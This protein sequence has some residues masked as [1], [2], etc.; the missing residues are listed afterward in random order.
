V[1]EGGLLEKLGLIYLHK[2][3]QPTHDTSTWTYYRVGGGTRTGD[4]AEVCRVD[5]PRFEDIGDP[6]GTP[7]VVGYIGVPEKLRTPAQNQWNV[8][9][10]RSELIGVLGR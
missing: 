6:I 8:D 9:P 3:A 2:P 7:F 4:T 1:K 10:E 5:F